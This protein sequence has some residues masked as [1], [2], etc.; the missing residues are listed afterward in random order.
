MPHQIPNNAYMCEVTLVGKIPRCADIQQAMYSVLHC[1]C[2]ICIKTDIEQTM[3]WSPTLCQHYVWRCLLYT[4]KEPLS[5]APPII[6][7]QIISMPAPAQYLY[8]NVIKYV[9]TT[10]EIK[11]MEGSNNW[12]QSYGVITED[13]D[14]LFQNATNRRKVQSGQ[15]KQRNE[16][17]ARQHKAA[18]IDHR[19]H[20]GLWSPGQ[21]AGMRPQRG[22]VW[23]KCLHYSLPH[24]HSWEL[25]CTYTIYNIHYTVYM[26]PL[27]STCLDQEWHTLFPGPG[28]LGHTECTMT[29]CIP[30]GLFVSFYFCTELYRCYFNFTTSYWC[31][32]SSSYHD[33]LQCH[34]QFLLLLL[35]SAEIL[36]VTVTFHF[37]APALIS[38]MP[39]L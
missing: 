24:R 20:T 37:T 36:N 23:V 9:M 12:S 11:I 1:I 3:L 31:F 21:D 25:T 17:N 7:S 29:L 28:V 2:I 15:G 8:S 14:H 10:N 18:I 6:Q 33:C 39:P 32:I 16:K 13:F 34:C 5:T 27:L 38:L 22:L 26:H 35:L 30:D 19:N 4:D